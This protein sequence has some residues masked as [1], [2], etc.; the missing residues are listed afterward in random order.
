[1]RRPKRTTRNLTDSLRRFARENSRKRGFT[2]IASLLLLLILS[3]LAVGILMMVNTE[4]KAGGNDEQ[5]TLAYRAAKNTIKKMT[6]DLANTFSQIQAPQ[7]SDI[8]ALNTAVPTTPGVTYVDYSLT[9][10]TKANGSPLTSYG[11]IKTGSY[12]GLSALT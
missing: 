10:A 8:T 9:P 3:G 11:Q 2:L 7:V 4:Q 6:S 1:M 5:N 12:Q